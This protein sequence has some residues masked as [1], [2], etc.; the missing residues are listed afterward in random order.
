TYGSLP[1]FP[2]T[3]PH[4]TRDDDIWEQN[5]SNELFAP[6][7]R[8][9]LSLVAFPAFT[10]HNSRS[11]SANGSTGSGMLSWLS[12]VFGVSRD[13]EQTEQLSFPAP[14]TYGVDAIHG[15]V[16]LVGFCKDPRTASFC[17]DRAV[18]KLLSAVV[19]DEIWRP[20]ID[21]KTKQRMGYAS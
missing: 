18:R 2:P 13:D 11:A 8:K 3:Q 4:P 21:L 5:E 19:G 12:G 9:K 14:E 16:A 6:G 10:I 1:V 15:Q 7:G 20:K 17:T